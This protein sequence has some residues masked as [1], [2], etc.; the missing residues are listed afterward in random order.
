MLLELMIRRLC[1]L[2]AYGQQTRKIVTS[3]TLSY[4]PFFYLGLTINN[5]RGLYD[6]QKGCF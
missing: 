5:D 3:S 1:V 6:N 4:L 2:S